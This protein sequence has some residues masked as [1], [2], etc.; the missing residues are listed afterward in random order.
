MLRIFGSPNRYIQGPDAL[1]QLGEILPNGITR[2]LM[3]VDGPMLESL[4]PQLMAGLGRH[5][6]TTMVLRFQGECTA[7]EIDRVAHAGEGCDVVIGVGGGKA[8]DTAKAVSIQLG[9]GVVIVPTIASN[10][11]PTSRLAVV[12]TDAHA[13]DS[14]RL[15]LRNPDAVVVDTRIIVAA[16][17]RFF[18]AGIGDA[19]SKKFE[20]EQCFKAGGRNFYQAAPPYLAMTLGAACYNT[21]LEHGELAVRAV[22]AHTLDENVERVVEATIL[23]S[24]LAFESGGLS[25]AH[26]ILR[27]FSIIPE[28]AASLHGEQVAMGLL[29]QL[30]LEQ[31]A[32][33]ELHGLLDFYCR[34]GLPCSF[35]MLG[36]GGDVSLV[37]RRIA[38]HAYDTAPY[39]HHLDRPLSVDSI[40]AALRMADAHGREAAM[41]NSTEEKGTCT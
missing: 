13:V 2:P 19:L 30:V 9:C 23:L 5:A 4:R 10:D 38:Q 39:I 29:V 18:L 22:R 11:S 3:L 21:L 35:A 15:M 41:A 6:P 12:Y 26:S 17:I 14:V 7:G 28:L 16:P 40:E 37:A 36:Y 33:A 24:G 34:I 27:G 1:S 25:I 32:P 20:A 31:R 8:I